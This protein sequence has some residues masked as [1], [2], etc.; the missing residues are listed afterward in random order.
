MSSQHSDKNVMLGAFEIGV[1]LSIFFFGVLC[2]QTY[3]YF[4]AFPADRRLNKILVC[5][6]PVRHRI[7]TS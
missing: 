7:L 5:I 1:M 6:L 2:V 3:T 4:D